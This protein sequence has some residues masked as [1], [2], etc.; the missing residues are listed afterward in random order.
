MP[1]AYTIYNSL[2]QTV[3]SQKVQSTSNLTINTS[4]FANGVYFIRVTKENASKT[5]QFIRN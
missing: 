3:A 1:E 5:L 4:S 2:G